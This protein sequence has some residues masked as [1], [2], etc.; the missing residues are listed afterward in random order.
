MSQRA[1]LYFVF[2]VWFGDGTLYI[3]HLVVCHFVKRRSRQPIGFFNPLARSDTHTQLMYYF[4]LFVSS[5]HGASAV[6]GQSRR[7]AVLL[8]DNSIRLLLYS[9]SKSSA[10]YISLRS[11]L[12]AK[13]EK[14]RGHS[15][16]GQNSKSK[17]KNYIG[18]TSSKPPSVFS[19]KLPKLP[20]SRKTLEPREICDMYSKRDIRA[21]AFLRHDLQEER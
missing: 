7:I 21:F 17:M 20:K 1:F 14:A 10:L 11:R 12:K 16:S 6:W 4:I 2:P 13:P 18:L 5:L 9:P 8:C 3:F 15:N 19:G